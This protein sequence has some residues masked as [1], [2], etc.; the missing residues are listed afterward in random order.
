MTDRE[1][2]IGLLQ[3]C[4]FVWVAESSAKMLAEHLL[5]HGVTIVED[6]TGETVFALFNVSDRKLK[7]GKTKARNVQI[8]SIKYLRDAMRYG[9]VEIKEKQCTNTDCN[10]IGK[11]V[12]LTRE[13][14]EKAVES[15]RVRHG[16][17]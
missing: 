8:F 9:N 10:Y 15:C 13:E 2:L 6:H 3:D 14:A 5:S 7:S 16:K 17:G 12:F 11:T 1:T 4:P